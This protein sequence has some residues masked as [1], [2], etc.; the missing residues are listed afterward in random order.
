MLTGMD[1]SVVMSMVG[2]ISLAGVVVNNAIVL[3]DYIELLKRE[4]REKLGLSEAVRLS[5]EQIKASIVKAGQTRLRPVLLTAITTVLGLVPLAIG[6]NIDLF[7]WVAEGDP[8]FYIGGDNVAFW[9]P[10]AWTVIYGMVFATN[11]TLV[12]VLVM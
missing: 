4:L 11:L 9:G 12:V 8:K 1:F 6:L 7:S 5:D 2:I 10:L 3:M